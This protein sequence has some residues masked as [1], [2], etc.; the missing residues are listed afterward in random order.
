M[1]TQFT[2]PTFNRGGRV[3]VSPEASAKRP[4]KFGIRDIGRPALQGH[5]GPIDIVRSIGGDSQ[6]SW[7][8]SD[9][10]SSSPVSAGISKFD[11]DLGAPLTYVPFRC[12]H[13]ALAVFAICT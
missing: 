10:M 2:Q 5:Q 6:S 13:A 8:R 11:H 12:A 3:S 9:I 1:P 7:K 4:V